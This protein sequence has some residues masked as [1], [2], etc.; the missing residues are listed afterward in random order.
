MKHIKKF[1]EGSSHEHGDGLGGF[2][3]LIGDKIDRG[4]T[5]AIDY[6]TRETDERSGKGGY[7][8]R[9]QQEQEKK[10][11]AERSA[12]S[13]IA[14]EDEEY[15]WVSYEEDQI[16]NEWYLEFGSEEPTKTEKM[17]WY[18]NMR[19]RGFDGILISNFIKKIKKNKKNKKK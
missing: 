9:W 5:N 17:E 4:L 1:N 14:D 18:H 11:A 16:E 3:N 7:K 19:K 6:I 15:D 10:H 12:M 8:T 2:L 13:R